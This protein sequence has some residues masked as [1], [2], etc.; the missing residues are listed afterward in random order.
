MILCDKAHTK[1]LPPVLGQLRR[2]LAKIPSSMVVFQELPT[3]AKMALKELTGRELN[4]TSLLG[5]LNLT[6]RASQQG[7]TRYLKLL[8]I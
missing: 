3:A 1:K 7:D 8:P 5:L 2:T 4:Q 6:H